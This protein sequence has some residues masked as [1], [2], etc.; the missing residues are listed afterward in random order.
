MRT[1]HTRLI[2]TLFKYSLPCKCSICT[3]TIKQTPFLSALNSRGSWQKKMGGG[4]LCVYV[5]VCTQ[6]WGSSSQSE[7]YTD[8][9][10]PKYCWFI[11]LSFREVTWLPRVRE[12][13]REGEWAMWEVRMKRRIRRSIKRVSRVPGSPWGVNWRSGKLM[14][15][16]KKKIKGKWDA[17]C[18]GLLG[19]H[20]NE[21]YGKWLR[22]VSEWMNEG[23]NEWVRI[24]ISGCS[25]QLQPLMSV[26]VMV[27]L[28]LPHTVKQI[29]PP[30]CLKGQFI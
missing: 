27:W 30:Q 26:I 21:P 17:G 2:I 19:F 11:G 24:D 22:D 6:Q 28:T 29:P 13:E 15:Q 4:L 1:A 14:E 9:E 5:C 23:R 7:S 12:W 8:T 3:H 18:T 16:K 25:N 20:L 10:P